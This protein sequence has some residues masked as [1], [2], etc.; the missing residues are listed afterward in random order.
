MVKLINKYHYGK[1]EYVSTI[2]DAVEYLK[3]KS[4]EYDVLITMGAGDVW[5]VAQKLKS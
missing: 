2:D 5:R 1:A 3:E 4:G